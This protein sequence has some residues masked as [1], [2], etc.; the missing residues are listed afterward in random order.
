M[1]PPPKKYYGICDFCNKLSTCV[2]VSIIPKFFSSKIS[3]ISLCRKCLFELGKQKNLY[4]FDKKEV[5][6]DDK[7]C[8][9]QKIKTF[10]LKFR[11]FF[12]K[13]TP[14]DETIKSDNRQNTVEDDEIM[15]G[16][17]TISES[18]TIKRD[19]M[20]AF[21]SLRKFNQ[22]E[23]IPKKNKDRRSGVYGNLEIFTDK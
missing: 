19:R 23:Y 21:G 11:T 10:L 5:K 7:I 18:N 1:V 22:D 14:K 6:S 20:N 3:N 9:T 16:N 12:Q 4:I 8:I 17:D 15:E 13:P 2:M